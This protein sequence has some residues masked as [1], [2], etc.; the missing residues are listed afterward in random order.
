MVDAAADADRVLLE[1]AQA[2]RRLARARDPGGIVGHRHDYVA[3]R[4]GDAAEAAEEIE[5]GAF[6]RQDGPRRSRD[7]RQGG[8]PVDIGAVG[9]REHDRERRIEHRERR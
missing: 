5:R 4:G 8:A 3:G 7:R 2:R 9:P 1:R 6:G